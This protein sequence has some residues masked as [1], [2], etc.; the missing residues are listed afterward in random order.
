MPIL[1]LSFRW[2]VCFIWALNRYVTPC[3]HSWYCLQW[4]IILLNF[5]QESLN[6]INV[7]LYIKGHKKKKNVVEALSAQS[8]HFMFNDIISFIKSHLQNPHL[9]EALCGTVGSMRKS[10]TLPLFESPAELAAW[11]RNSIFSWKN[12]WQIKL[13]LNYTDR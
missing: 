4:G 6:K 5:L 8:N 9:L 11:P 7:F 13:W 12:D 1:L 3:W 2:S 10:S